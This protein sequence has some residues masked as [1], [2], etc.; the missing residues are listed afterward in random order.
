LCAIGGEAFEQGGAAQQVEVGGDFIEQEQAW[1][2]GLRA[3]DFAM[4]QRQGDQHGFLLA[5]G[6]IG[7]G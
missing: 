2:G 5:G 6:A 4:G 7:G 3:R 1:A